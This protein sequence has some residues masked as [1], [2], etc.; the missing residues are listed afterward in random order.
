MSLNDY[1]ERRLSRRERTKRVVLIFDQFE[2]ILTVE[3]D[4][5]G[6]QGGVLRPGRRGA[7]RPPALG[8]VLDA[9]GLRRRARSRTC[10]RSRRGSATRFRLDLLGATA[11]R[12]GDPGAG[13]RRRRRRSPT[14]PR[15]G[16]ADDL[17]ACGCSGPTAHVEEQRA[18]R[19]AGPAPGRLLP[20][21]GAAARRRRADHRGGRG[22]PVGDVDTALA[23]YYAEHVARGRPP[24]PASASGRS[25]TGSS[26]Q[27]IT[28]QGIARA[29]APGAEQSQGLANRAIEPLIDAHLVRAEKRRGATWFELAHDRLIEPIRANNAA[30]REAHLSSLQRQAVLW[31][32]R[33]GPTACCCAMPLWPRPRH[34][35]PSRARSPTSS[36]TFWRAAGGARDI[37]RARRNKRL[38]RLLAVVA[39]VIGVIAVVLTVLALQARDQ[40][41]VARTEAIARQLAAQSLRSPRDPPAR[42]AAGGRGLRAADQH[43][44]SER[45]VGPVC[46]A[47]DRRRNIAA[48]PSG[49]D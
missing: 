43:A 31:T 17:A 35:R 5:P 37:R 46:R 48:G 34:G 42:A 44:H 7:A 1:L 19:R 21:L 49:T 15:A 22:E 4:R 40:A 27:L 36:T 28:A 41:E 45:E 29:G 11:A 38:I 20:P 18:R 9:R 8:A 30:W 16:S 3:P 24:R 39:S 32:A 10:G 33:A 26:A 14:P 47:G 13:A 12:A 23:G 2:E 6:G 25:A